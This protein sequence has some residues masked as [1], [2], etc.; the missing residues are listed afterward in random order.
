MGNCFLA[1][2]VVRLWKEVTEEP[3]QG[4]SGSDFGLYK[5]EA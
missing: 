3:L 4:P 1:F 5:C 2:I